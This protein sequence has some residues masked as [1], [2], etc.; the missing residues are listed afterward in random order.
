MKTIIHRLFLV[1]HLF[2]NPNIGE[3]DTAASITRQ[4]TENGRIVKVMKGSALLI[5]TLLA[6]ITSIVLSSCSNSN[7]VETLLNQQVPTELTTE[8]LIAKGKYLATTSACH[9]CHSPKIMT[10]HGPIIDTTRILSGH[11]KENAVPDIRKTNEWVMFNNE[12]TAFV[13]PWGLSYAANLTPDDTGTGSW[14]FEQFKTA[15]RKGKYKGLEG[16][17]NLLPPMPWEMYQHFTDE[18]L[19]ALFTF[20]Q[21]IKPINNLVPNPV[22]PGDLTY[23]AN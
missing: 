16:S 6:I 12:A 18:D 21:S 22:A 9:D 19:L 5:G 7:K 8:A 11:P 20:L 2:E 23:A 10:P 13:G 17:R 14:S 4:A 1:S 15:I 3:S